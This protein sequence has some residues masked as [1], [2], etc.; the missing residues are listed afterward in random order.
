MKT[1]RILSAAL[2]ALT[3]APAAF[4]NDGAQERTEAVAPAAA[5]DTS[6]AIEATNE[7][8]SITRAVLQR[9]DVELRAELLESLRESALGLLKTATPVLS[10]TATELARELTA[11]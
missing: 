8:A 11:R 10:D 6:I 9:L 7:V 2:F 1:T 3:L 4:A 5:V